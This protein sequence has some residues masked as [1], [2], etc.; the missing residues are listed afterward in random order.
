MIL[1]QSLLI[2]RTVPRINM[3]RINTLSTL[4]IIKS[5]SKTAKSLTILLNSN[6]RLLTRLNTLL[7]NTGIR[8]TI[9]S[10]ITLESGLSGLR[11]SL[12]NSRRRKSTS[13]NNITSRNRNTILSLLT[14]KRILRRNRRITRLL[15][16][17]IR[18]KRTISSKRDKTLNRTSSILIAIGTDRRSIRRQTRGT[19]NITR[20]LIATRL[21][22]TETVRLDVTTRI[23][24]DNLRKGADTNK[25]LLRSRTGT[26]ITRRIQVVAIGLSNLLRYRTGVLGDRSLL[27]NRIINISRVLERYRI[28]FLSTNLTSC[29]CR[30]LRRRTSY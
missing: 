17:V 12:K 7:S 21:S 28:S 22:N 13:L 14:L 4:S 24:R 8:T 15:H 2:M 10:L 16:K 25:S 19:D 1:T 9:K 3:S 30:T 29:C 5:S 26:L 27:F 23:N 6:R 20:K 11:T 18:L